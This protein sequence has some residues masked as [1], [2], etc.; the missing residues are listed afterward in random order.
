[1]MWGSVASI[2]DVVG[3]LKN[4]ATYATEKDRARNCGDRLKRQFH[5][6]LYG[7]TGLRPVR[8]AIMVANCVDCK[9]IIASTG[10]KRRRPVSR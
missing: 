9:L 10:W 3:I 6:R 4:K 7:D 5:R 8:G 2:P 1:M